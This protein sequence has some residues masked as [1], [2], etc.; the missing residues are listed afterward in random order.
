[1]SSKSERPVSAMRNLIHNFASILLW[2]LF[3]YYWYVVGSRQINSASIAAVGLLAAITVV[4]VAITL[5]WIAHNKKLALR[6]ERKNAPPTSPEVFETDYLGRELV[7]P[8]IDILKE[9]GSIVI[10]LDDTGHKVYTVAD[11]AVD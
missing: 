11:G 2:C 9:A 7:S 10:S 5:W 4:G 1:M 6:N 8:G 3:G